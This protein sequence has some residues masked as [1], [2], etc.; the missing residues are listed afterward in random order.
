MIVFFL[1]NKSREKISLRL[2][3]TADK[4]GN[5]V[6]RTCIKNEM[7]SPS[8]INNTYYSIVQGIDGRLET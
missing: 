8:R 1:K 7:N 2:V 6:G 3:S 4:A 5:I